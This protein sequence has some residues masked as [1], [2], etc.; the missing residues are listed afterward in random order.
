MKMSIECRKR[1][2]VNMNSSIDPVKRCIVD[3]ETMHRNRQ[4]MHSETLRCLKGDA[5]LCGTL[6]TAHGVELSAFRAKIYL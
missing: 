4:T 2:V 1:C 3:M 6:L 5:L